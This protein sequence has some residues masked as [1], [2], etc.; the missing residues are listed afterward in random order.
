MFIITTIG[1]QPL[2][3]MRCP[4]GSPVVKNPPAN[5]GYTGSIPGPERSHMLWD[6]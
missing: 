5:G 2:R 3:I 6:K 4:P 1:V